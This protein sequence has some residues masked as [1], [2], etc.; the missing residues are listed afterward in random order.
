MTIIISFPGDDEEYEVGTLL[1][2]DACYL[3]M[4][5]DEDKSIGR[6]FRIPFEQVGSPQWFS[7]VPQ[8][9]LYQVSKEND[10]ILPR[11]HQRVPCRQSIA[12]EQFFFSLELNP[13]HEIHLQP[14]TSSSSSTVVPDSPPRCTSASKRKRTSRGENMSRQAPPLGTFAKFCFFS[15]KQ[16]IVR[17]LHAFVDFGLVGDESLLHT[18]GLVDMMV[19]KKTRNIDTLVRLYFPHSAASLMSLVDIDRLQQNDERDSVSGLVFYWY[20]MRM[21]FLQSTSRCAYNSS[22]FKSVLRYM[23]TANPM[24]VDDL[25]FRN[26]LVNT[27]GN[28]FVPSLKR[29]LDTTSL[30]QKRCFLSFF[31]KDTSDGIELGRYYFSTNSFHWAHSTADGFANTVLESLSTCG[32]TKKMSCFGKADTKIVFQ[33]VKLTSP[34]KV[35][36]EWTEEN[37]TIFFRVGLDGTYL[38][39]YLSKDRRLKTAVETHLFPEEMNVDVEEAISTLFSMSKFLKSTLTVSKTPTHKAR[40]YKEVTEIRFPSRPSDIALMMSEMN[41]DASLR[42]SFNTQKVNT[43]IAFAVVAFLE[44]ITEADKAAEELESAEELEVLNN[45]LVDDSA[46]FK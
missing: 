20:T 45:F 41:L 14:S 10:S 11:D 8:R 19:C 28:Q 6:L 16:E 27:S 1:P 39:D 46:N 22:G 33:R 25:Q 3:Y 31:S 30:Q 43:C 24:N 12:Y 9:S 23:R 4:Y 42:I 38:S 7:L 37:R 36:N 44:R 26:A 40:Q 5:S 18:F 35:R 2:D 34:L 29:A 15:A 17:L 13:E 32:G 21:L